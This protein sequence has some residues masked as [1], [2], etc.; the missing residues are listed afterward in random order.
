[1]IYAPHILQVKRIIPPATDEFG[2]PIPE[3]GSERYENVCMCRCD[4][5]T[6]KEFRSE[7]G[8]VYRP[9]YHIVCNGKVDIKAGERVRCLDNGVVRGEGQVYILKCTNYFNYTELWI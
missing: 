5:N 9:A 8:S 3:N 4:D 2:R 6:T 7:N 1:M